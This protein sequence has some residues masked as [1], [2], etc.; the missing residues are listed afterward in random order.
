MLL[1]KNEVLVYLDADILTYP[2][3]IVELLGG[4]IERDETDF[5]KSFFDR[6]AG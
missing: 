1:A 3:D 2:S 6:Q 5:V 4:P